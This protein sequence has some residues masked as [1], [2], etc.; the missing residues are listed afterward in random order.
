MKIETH[1]EPRYAAIR[2]AGDFETYAISEFLEAVEAARNAGRIYVVLNMR[3]VK[4]I[5]STAIGAILRARKELKASGGGL[6][7]APTSGFVRDVFEKLG[8]DSVIPNYE[9]EKQAAIQLRMSGSEKSMEAEPGD[10]DAALFFRFYEQE[11]ADKL[12]G[13]G[14]GAGEIAT[15][16]TSGITFSWD[17]R[18]NRFSDAELSDLLQSGTE[19]EVKFRLP[20]YSK[21]TYYQSPAEVAELDVEDGAARVRARFTGLDDE[22]AKAVRQYVADMTLVKEE[23]EQA[24]N[25]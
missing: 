18:G 19:I 8:L 17:G 25:E 5:N 15:L 6:A 13:R 21:S 4:F 14:V 3:R 24:K 1:I 16:D 20:L 9:D 2:L 23:I 10:E 12:G 22:A 11:K 7:L